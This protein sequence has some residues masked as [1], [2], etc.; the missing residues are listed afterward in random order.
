MLPAGYSL[1]IIGACF[2]AC[3]MLGSCVQAA[4]LNAHRLAGG[5][6]VTA[7]DLA[8]FY[9][10]GHNLSG[11]GERAEY[12]TSFAQLQMEKD[13]R[14]LFL[15]GVQH[16]LGAPIIAARGQLWISS[17]DV[18]KTIDP[19]LRQGR[20]RTP[21]AVRTIVIDP[22]HGGTDRG[23]RGAS[24][25]EKEMT[26]DLA[27]RVG[28]YLEREGVSAVLTRA[29]DATTSLEDRV[30]FAGSRHT[31]LFV[32]IHF[33]SG[34]S[35][36]GIESYCVPP[37]GTFSTADAA[38]RSGRGDDE[39]CPGNRWDEKNVWLAHCVQ[40][41]LVKMT[42]AGDR[43]VRRARF[44][45]LRYAPCPAILVEAGF[46]SNRTEERKILSSEYRDQLARAISEGIVAYKKS[47]ETP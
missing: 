6:Y 28:R 18:L 14:E 40:K 44:Y 19:V 12:K 11:T 25:I 34:G 22:G 38:R 10:L 3:A 17:T 21:S 7:G 4:T 45:V 20:S 15:N 47:V 39:S 8:R 46:L 31:D 5:E 24:A 9:S 30:D 27:K 13:R 26:L 42:G 37:A 43:G 41:S 1:K 16:W 32:S 23:T 36:D 35:A 33:N 29:T 2:V